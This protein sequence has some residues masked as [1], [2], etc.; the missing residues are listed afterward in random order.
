MQS[1][2]NLLPGTPYRRSGFPVGRDGALKQRG[3]DRV[4]YLP[5]R[6]RPG[7]AG[8]KVA[9]CLSPTA[10]NQPAPPQIIQDLHQKVA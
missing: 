7:I 8:Q 6:N 2:G 3:I 4:H 9:A 5:E 1:E 10:F